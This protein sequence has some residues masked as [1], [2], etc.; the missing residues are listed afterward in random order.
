MAWLAATCDW[1]SKELVSGVL[2]MP[3]LARDYDVTEL[4]FR[5]KDIFFEQHWGVKL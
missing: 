4:E 1:L 3:T 2:K 5:E